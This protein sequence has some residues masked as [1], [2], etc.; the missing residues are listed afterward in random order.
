MFRI[1]FIHESGV[2]QCSALVRRSSRRQPENHEGKN[3][4]VRNAVYLVNGKPYC[5]QH[6]RGSSL[7]LSEMAKESSRSG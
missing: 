6:A 4:C 1:D 3:R 5:A 2:K 7:M